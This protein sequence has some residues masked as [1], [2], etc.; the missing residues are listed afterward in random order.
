MLP[1]D[2]HGPIRASFEATSILNFQYFR[3]NTELLQPL[4]DRYT[5][6]KVAAMGLNLA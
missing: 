5:D 4:P 6:V 1:I 3:S 2:K